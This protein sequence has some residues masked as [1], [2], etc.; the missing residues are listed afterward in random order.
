MHKVFKQITLGIFCIIIA[1]TVIVAVAACAFFGFNAGIIA[2]AIFLVLAGGLEV[3]LE[4]AAP[5]NH[6]KEYEQE[7]KKEHNE[8]M[9]DTE[10]NPTL[11]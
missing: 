2:G 10:A 11:R 9:K 8:F 1:L 6:E 4:L 5:K 7:R 3:L